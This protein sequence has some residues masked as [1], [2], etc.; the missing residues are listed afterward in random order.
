MVPFASHVEN[1]KEK[2]TFV[3]FRK[4]FYEKFI[5]RK[6]EQDMSAL[7]VFTVFVDR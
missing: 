5:S 3:N 7:N 1:L 2:S 6:K 4:D